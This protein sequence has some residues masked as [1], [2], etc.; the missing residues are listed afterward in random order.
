MAL[1]DWPCIAWW[2]DGPQV[3][4]F[5]IVDDVAMH[6]VGSESPSVRMCARRLGKGNQVHLI[7][8]PA[9]NPTHIDPPSELQPRP[10]EAEGAAR[11]APRALAKV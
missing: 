5:F 3:N 2:P 8:Q 9:R 11:G 10:V 1:L 4:T 7:R 6:A